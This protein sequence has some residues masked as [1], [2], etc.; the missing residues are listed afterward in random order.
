V[1]RVYA[2][3]N[4]LRG[5]GRRGKPAKDC[6]K[7]IPRIGRCVGL[8]VQLDT[9]RPELPGLVPLIAVHIHENAHAS[10]AIVEL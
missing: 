9:I 7:V 8:R 2:Q 10:T 5:L 4:Q 1:T 3:T 6:L